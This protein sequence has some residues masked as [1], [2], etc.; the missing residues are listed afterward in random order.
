VPPTPQRVA[1]VVF[2]GFSELDT[3]VTFGLLNRLSAAGWKAELVAPSA[4]VTS[5]NG[6]T[7]DTPQPLEFANEADAVVFAGGLYAR[8][9]AENS[10]VID[11]LALDPLRQLIGGQCSG[12][13]LLARLGLL[14]DVPA[15]TDV[16]SKPWMVQAGVRV[17]DDTPFHARGPVATAG[18]PLAA[19][20]L[21]TWLMWRAAGI[22]LATQALHQAAPVGQRQDWTDRLLATVRPFMP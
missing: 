20:Y 11:R 14:A 22:D 9:I 2:D 17:A 13:L 19:H 15:S 7:V 21:A 10:A 18:G 8:A 1:I 5:M 3:F 16:T 6:V 12:T 4:R